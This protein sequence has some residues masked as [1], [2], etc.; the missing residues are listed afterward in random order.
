MISSLDLILLRR[1]KPATDTMANSLSTLEKRL[2]EQSTLPIRLTQTPAT[3]RVRPRAGIKVG[4]G[5]RLN[6]ARDAEQRAE[7][8]ECDF[9]RSRPRIPIGSRPPIP[10]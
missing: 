1:P 7:G 8:V 6:P 3:C 5:R 10:I 2:S 9:R 4:I